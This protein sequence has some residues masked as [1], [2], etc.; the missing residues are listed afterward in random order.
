MSAAVATEY[1]RRMIECE[2]G[3]AERSMTKL[4]A[5]YG[6]GFWTLDHFRR[7]KAKTCDVGLFA[8]IQAAFVDHCGTHAARLLHEAQ[9]AQAVTP[10]DD[11]AAIEDEIRAL[12]SRLAAAKAAAQ[13]TGSVK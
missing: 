12:A 7:R 3:D 1:V 13:K 6:I 5:K 2:G 11:V 10:D 8:R 4:E 9:M